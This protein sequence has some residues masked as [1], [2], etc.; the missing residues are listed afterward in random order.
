M[1]II[2]FVAWLQGG[3]FWSLKVM[4]TRHWRMSEKLLNND[5]EYNPFYCLVGK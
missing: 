2:Y 3:Y 4:F 5:Y 1:A